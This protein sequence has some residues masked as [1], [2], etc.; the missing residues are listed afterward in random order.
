MRRRP[1]G[2]SVP[3]ETCFLQ[4]DRLLASPPPPRVGKSF[5][6][7][8]CQTALDNV[9]PRS[10]V[11]VRAVC[12]TGGQIKVLHRAQPGRTVLY[13]LVHCGSIYWIYTVFIAVNIN[14]W[15]R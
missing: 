14:C 6:T 12:R 3:R 15:I 7:S 4:D 8:G 2:S 10:F 9:T 5:D 11:E 1:A 13:V